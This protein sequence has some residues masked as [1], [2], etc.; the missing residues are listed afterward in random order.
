M[1][2]NEEKTECDKRLGFCSDTPQAYSQVKKPLEIYTFID[3]LCPECWAFEPTLKKLQVEYG[4]YFHLRYIVAGK[5][6]TWNSKT[7][8]ALAA[9][10]AKVWEKTANRTGMSCDGGLWFEDPISSPYATAIAIKA[11]EM[12]GRQAGMKFLRKIQEALFLDKQNI[13]K[14]NVLIHCAEEVGID[15]KEFR[16]DL[17]SEG[18]IKALRFDMKI[19]KEM[20]IDYVPTFVFFNDKI[21]EEGLMVTGP[22]QYSVY[23]EIIERLLG[24]KPQRD[25]TISIETFLK[26]YRFVATK[27]VAVVFDIS[28]CEAERQLKKLLLKQVVEKV[29]V[30]HGTFWRYLSEPK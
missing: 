21:E 20:N 16:N 23:V 26:R 24:Y 7:T 19:T 14:E 8:P 13:S 3:P 1:A 6:D 28:I 18:A 30:K 22:Y 4:T 29:P 27:E 2:P 10:I 15:V 11:A 9:N 12:Q 17:H 5:L 25:E